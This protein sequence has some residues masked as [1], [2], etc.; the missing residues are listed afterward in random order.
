M[1]PITLALVCLNRER[2]EFVKAGATPGGPVAS[3][4][5]TIDRRLNKEKKLSTGIE[6]D[7]FFAY[8]STL[9]LAMNVS[10]IRFLRN[11]CVS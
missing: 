3:K 8:S 9:A 11:T 10:T 6:A 4:F 2:A 5:L 7:K 1:L